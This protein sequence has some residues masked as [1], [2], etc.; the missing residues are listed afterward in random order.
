[1][2]RHACSVLCGS[3]TGNEAQ[4]LEDRYPG[5]RTVVE[6]IVPQGVTVLF[7]YAFE[8]SVPL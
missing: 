2:S 3:G 5:T 8:A 7:S 6:I 4:G 1:M